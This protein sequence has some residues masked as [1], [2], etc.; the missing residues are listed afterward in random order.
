MTLS[1]IRL[2]SISSVLTSERVF[3][4]KQFTSTK[5]DMGAAEIGSLLGPDF[6]MVY[7]VIVPFRCRSER[8]D[9]AE[10]HSFGR[11]TLR[12]TPGPLI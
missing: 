5:P 11:T 4:P 9:I 1:R 3:L 7:R 6:L 12:W 8:L 2:P 10:N